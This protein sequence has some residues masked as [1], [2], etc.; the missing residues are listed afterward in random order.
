MKRFFQQFDNKKIKTLAILSVVVLVF[1]II[2][3]PAA[4]GVDQ[5]VLEGMG[6]IT[7]G[8]VNFLGKLIFLVIRI[9]VSLAQY[10]GFVSSPVVTIGW[11]LIRDIC[12]MLF[13]VI[14]LVMAFATVLQIESYSYKRLLGALVFAAV[15][16]NFSKGIC[17]ILIDFSQVV[18]LTFINAVQGAVEGNFAQLIGLSQFL[19]T[20]I[21]K[22]QNLGGTTEFE[23]VVTYL[24]AI[25][26]AVVALV[27]IT[28][29]TII[30]LLRIIQLWFL[31]ML[32][33]IAFMAT[34][35]PK[36]STYANKWWDK[37]TNQLIIGPVLALFL[38]L[39]LAIVQESSSKGGLVNYLHVGEGVSNPQAQGATFLSVG[40]G[41]IGT[42]AG[43]LGYMIGIAILV[44][45][46]GMAQELSVAGAGIAGKA[47]DKMKSAARGA[48]KWTGGQADMRLRQL[49][50]LGG[51][52][53][54]RGKHTKGFAKRLGITEDF[55]GFGVRTLGQAIKYRAARA[56]VEER[57][58]IM[59]GA[60]TMG[61]GLVQASHLGF[62]TKQ[63]SQNI[64][65]NKR[66]GDAARDEAAKQEKALKALEDPSKGAFGTLQA[67]IDKLSES[68]NQ[69]TAKRELIDDFM[70]DA[71]L[72]TDLE[73][74]SGKFQQKLTDMR[75]QGLIDDP[76]LKWLHNE[77]KKDP[78]LAMTNLKTS[79]KIKDSDLYTQFVKDDL[80]KRRIEKSAAY[81]AA[82]KDRDDTKAKME[83]A[84][85][86][87]YK[88]YSANFLNRTVAGLGYPDKEDI[89]A[90][91]KLE[92]VNEKLKE[93]ET[94]LPKG[95]EDAYIGELLKRM[96]AKDGTGIEAALKLV[97]SVKGQN[98][99]GAKSSWHTR[100]GELL[101]ARYGADT[102]TNLK[103]QFESERS[104]HV[105]LRD[106]IYELMKK[107]GGYG[108]QEA[109]RVIQQLANIGS[110]VGNHSLIGA[111]QTDPINGVASLVDGVVV[112]N[113]V[114]GKITI[115]APDAWRDAALTRN[116]QIEPQKWAQNLH[117][118]TLATQDDHGRPVDFHEAGYDFLLHGLTPAMIKQ[119]NR[120]RDDTRNYLWDLKDKVVDMI[121]Y[122]HQY[123]DGH[124]DTLTGE[125]KKILQEYLNELRKLSLA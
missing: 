104:N 34:V 121:R 78:K 105:F 57:E 25:V 29:I 43:L 89:V 63:V 113:K 70:K 30:I 83:A 107:D 66:K 81:I 114:T 1:L 119:L 35:L 46:L 22:G 42:S 62:W 85:S 103:P 86:D 71:K 55:K 77:A 39:A 2:P 95:D 36:T 75:N 28:V 76:T 88:H 109:T 24:L 51:R 60:S 48:T 101:N 33:P 68:I 4:A 3:K 8:I 18:M 19:S 20:T 21:N 23:I 92:K 100:A 11:Q 26:L 7:S 112:T 17:G 69:A 54:A 87:A 98:T 5:W 16:V 93:M 49:T 115:E 80:N 124:S 116:S 125:Q 84:S 65:Q 52:A 10:N 94:R 59:L 106:T 27:V 118:N 37:F 58:K 111:V 96:A 110:S 122:G 123:A 41:D 53:L 90:R 79:L 117:I 74:D 108:D 45:S 12:N 67:A 50:G 82:T 72:Q 102:F 97:Y 9:L 99:L 44:A 40:M 31:T 61:Q 120:M 64:L 38:W 73:L 32:S 56:K 13:V 91:L 6:W 15:L 14:L 47:V